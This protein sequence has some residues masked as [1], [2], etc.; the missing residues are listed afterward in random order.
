MKKIIITMCMVFVLIFSVGFIAV[1][2]KNQ[3]Q[4]KEFALPK[5]AVEVAPGVFY[6]GYALDKGK[7]VEGYAF[8]MKNSQDKKVRKPKPS[9]ESSCYTFLASGAKWKTVEPYI[10][11][12]KNTIVLDEA[13]IRS[14]LVLDISKWESSVGIEILG[15]ENPAG[16]VNRDSIGSLNGANEVMF[17]D[18]DSP[19]AIGI[20][21]IWGIFGGRPSSRV[22]VEWDMVFDD[23]DFDWSATGEPGK[24]D[25]EN[26]ATHELGHAVGLGDLY[27]SK[28]SSQT[29]Y[30]YSDYGETNKRDLESGDISG[31][32]ALYGSAP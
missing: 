17:G 31:I 28:C 23:V 29:M 6:L 26:I 32:Q 22:L 13:F 14:N 4:D 11:D 15:E 10:V 9:T 12:T 2:A 7:I 1:S 25:F 5:N 24:M 19:G 21:I 3:K 30:G 8:L 18:I 20:T 16:E 27:N